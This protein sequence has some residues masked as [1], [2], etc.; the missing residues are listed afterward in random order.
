MKKITR[1]IPQVITINKTFFVACDGTE[2]DSEELCIRHERNIVDTEYRSKLITCKELEDCCNFDGGEY[3]EN[4]SY[5]W[6]LI[7]NKEDAER[8]DKVFSEYKGE[9]IN[10]IG[11]WVCVE[12][13]GEW[14]WL[15]YLSNGIENVKKMLEILGY[16]VEITKKE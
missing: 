15:S 16:N 4:H 7:R 5:S 6:Y 1:K 9:F 14:Y 8:L 12:S 10:H 11:D 2:F 3:Y 13:D